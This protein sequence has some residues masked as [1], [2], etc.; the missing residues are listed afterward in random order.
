MKIGNKYGYKYQVLE[1]LE[2]NEEVAATGGFLIDSESQLK[3][4]LQSGHQHGET[5]TPKKGRSSK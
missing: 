5:R 4:G 1:G 2:E 3:S